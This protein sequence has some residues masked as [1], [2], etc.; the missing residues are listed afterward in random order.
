MALK[1][2]AEY[3]TFF[4]KHIKNLN[5]LVTSG[6]LMVKYTYKDKLKLMIQICYLVLSL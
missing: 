1:T 4:Y 5:I 3:G 6:M 2:Y